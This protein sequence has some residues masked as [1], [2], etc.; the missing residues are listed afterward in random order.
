[1][2]KKKSGI[3][4][5]LTKAPELSDKTILYIVGFAIV[6]A[7]LSNTYFMLQM[8]QNVQ[9]LGKAILNIQVKV[10]QET[11]SDGAQEQTQPQ[12][13]PTELLQPETKA[14]V[15]KYSISGTPTLVINCNKKRVGTYALAEERGALPK[16]SELQTIINDLCSIAGDGSV[17]CNDVGETNATG[18]SIET[19]TDAACGSSEKVRIYSFHSPTCGYCDSQETVLEEL[20]G[21][22]PNN[23]EV[24]TVCTPIHGADDVTLC[25][26]QTDKYEMI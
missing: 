9:D 23:V 20:E 1:M 7:N 24:I 22:Y 15:Q 21:K 13:D 14:L 4:I 25:K 26:Q 6:V 16:G 10:P 12:E 17:F 5:D 3:P 2:V 11:P 18:I 19:T 8:N